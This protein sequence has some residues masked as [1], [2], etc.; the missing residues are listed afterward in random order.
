LKLKKKPAQAHDPVSNPSHYTSSGISPL[1]AIEA[2]GL[3]FA[4]GNVIK[5]VARAGKKD[6]EDPIQALEKAAWYLQR[7][8]S[9]L[10]NERQKK[11]KK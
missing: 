10:K 8:I 4:L 5:Y 2:W 7:H 11:D 6:G 3:G 1:D 9:N